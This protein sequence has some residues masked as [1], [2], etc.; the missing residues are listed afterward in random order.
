M[1]LTSK[2]KEHSYANFVYDMI[3]EYIRETTKPL[4]MRF[5]LQTPR[6][7]IIMNMT[8]RIFYM[9]YDRSYDE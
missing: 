1:T 2:P 4:I 3:T 7:K 5:I 8:Q 6:F 9:V